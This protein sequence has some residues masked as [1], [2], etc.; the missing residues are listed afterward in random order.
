MP[1]DIGM[2]FLT[3]YD[4]LVYGHYSGF[5]LSSGG[6]IRSKVLT[7]LWRLKDGESRIACSMV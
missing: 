2:L 6:L 7:S 1:K 4:S 5:I 3:L